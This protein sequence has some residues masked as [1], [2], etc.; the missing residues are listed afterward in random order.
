MTLLWSQQCFWTISK[1]FQQR[2]GTIPFRIPNLPEITCLSQIYVDFIFNSV[3]T[4]NSFCKKK[5]FFN[6]INR[7]NWGSMPTLLTE[8]LNLN[9]H[10]NN[11]WCSSKIWTHQHHFQIFWFRRSA[12]ESMNMNLKKKKHTI[13]MAIHNQNLRKDCL[14]AT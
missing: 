7:L 10:K 11:S 13:L 5:K 2:K 8:I 6:K 1:V 3:I 4:H 14:V 9:I 12:G